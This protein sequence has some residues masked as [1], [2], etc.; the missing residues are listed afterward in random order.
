MRAMRDPVCGMDVDLDDGAVGPREHDGHQL[1]FCSY[2]CLGRFDE[3]P[4]RYAAPSPPKT[5]REKAAPPIDRV[6]R[7]DAVRAEADHR[8]I[9]AN[10]STPLTAERMA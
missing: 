3:D 5:A 1:W 6:G 2:E 7:R 9:A 10:L 8:I 4:E